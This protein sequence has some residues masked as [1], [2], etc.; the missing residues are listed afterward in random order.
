MNEEKP[1]HED[2]EQARAMIQYISTEHS[3]SEQYVY[4]PRNP[5]FKDNLA[6]ADKREKARLEIDAARKRRQEQGFE[7]KKH[8]SQ[9]SG[10]EYE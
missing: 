9:E 6:A 3:I 4:Q 8:F 10:Y 1:T 5:Y 7:Y 2:W